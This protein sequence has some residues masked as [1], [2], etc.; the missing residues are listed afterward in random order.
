MERMLNKRLLFC[1]SCKRFM[2][3]FAEIVVYTGF[4]RTRNNLVRMKKSKKYVEHA[5]H[6]SSSVIYI[7]L[8]FA[9]K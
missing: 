9:N 4:M 3:V 2:L 5:Q 1:N 8:F 6:T 7:D